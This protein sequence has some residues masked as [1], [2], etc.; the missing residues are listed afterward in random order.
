MRLIHFAFA[1]T[2]ILLGITGFLA[3]EGR[4]EAQGARAELEFIRKQRADMGVDEAG[5]QLAVERAT[6]PLSKEEMTP[7]SPSLSE[8]GPAVATTEMAGTNVLGVSTDTASE[9]PPIPGGRKT[10]ETVSEIPLLTSKQK[11]VLDSDV[12]ARIK[13]AKLEQGFVVI[14]A[15]LDKELKAGQT[16]DVRR[17]SALVGRVELTEIIEAKESVADVLAG[18]TPPGVKIE[19]GDELV[20]PLKN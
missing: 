6:M 5:R 8:P 12:V 17:S 3:W 4:Q 14:D 1:I 16:F 13:V 7:T 2:V 11:L 18:A 19:E 10:P 15:G 20:V 9:P